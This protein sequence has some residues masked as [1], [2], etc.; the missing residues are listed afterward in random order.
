MIKTLKKAAA[1]SGVEVDI[2][3]TGQPLPP[4]SQQTFLKEK[5][6]PGL[7]L[8]DHSSSYTNKSVS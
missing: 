3:P 2:A 7:L 1:L 5:S 4:A 6:L 8:A